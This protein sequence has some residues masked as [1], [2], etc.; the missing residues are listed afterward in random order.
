MIIVLDFSQNINSLENTMGR[1]F[2]GDAQQR[3]RKTS[4]RELR[5]AAKLG[6]PE[7]FGIRRR[8]TYESQEP[9]LE[10]FGKMVDDGIIPE[11]VTPRRSL[12][13]TEM[14]K[15]NIEKQLSR[16]IIIGYEFAKKRDRAQR[17]IKDEFSDRLVVRLGA[18][19]IFKQGNLGFRIHSEQLEREY[20]DVRE[21]IGRTG[22]KGTMRDVEPLHLT[23]G[24]SRRHLRRL[25]M[26]KAFDDMNAV[27]NA[28]LS[29]PR[30]LESDMLYFP[31]EVTLD[32]IEFYP[33]DF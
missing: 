9:I 27:L 32:P 29:E 16:G 11:S 31:K 21:M 13:V 19:A 33:N 7:P 20:H 14:P 17:D 4:N 12:H 24:D 5:M 28:D 15:T 26:F 3:T 23:L 8:L 25:D 30:F 18:A 22:V 2:R 10:T 6:S 1:K